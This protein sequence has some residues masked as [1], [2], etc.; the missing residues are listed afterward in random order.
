MEG[1]EVRQYQGEDL[2]SVADFRENSIKGPQRVDRETYRLK[3]SG[4]VNKPLELAYDEVLADRE[5]F[6]KVVT[7]DCVEGWSVDIL[8]EGILVQDLLEA[9]GADPDASTIIFRAYDGY[10]TSL[11]ADF[12]RDNDLIMAYKVNGVELPTERGFPFQLVAEDKWGYKWIKWIVGIEVSDDSSY[13]GY[14]EQRGYS[15]DGDLS[16]GFL[17]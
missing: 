5:R 17:E 10:S 4:K 7:L 14:W 8:W 3:V 9:A 6:Q 12:I 1:V 2:S 15:N 11:P 16:K 13:K